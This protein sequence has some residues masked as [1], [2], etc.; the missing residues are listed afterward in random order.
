[1]FINYL[2]IAFRNVLKYKGYSFI[3]ILGLAIGLACTIVILAFVQNELKVD[4]HHQKK[5]DIVQ[6]YLKATKDEN[7]NF[8]ST[9]SPYIGPMLKNE[10][11]EIVDAIRMRTLKERGFQYEDIQLLQTDGMASDANIFDIFTF[12][13]LKGNPETAL[14]APRS[15]VLTE[16]TVKKYFRNDDPLGKMIKVDGQYDFKVT[17]VIEDVPV[18]SFRT[19]E[20]LVPLSFLEEIGHDIVGRPYFPCNYLTFVLLEPNASL[21][22]LNAKISERM[23]SEGKEITFDI[24]LI[25]YN[26]VYFFETGGKTRLTIMSFVA[27]MILALACINFVNLATARH[28]VRAKEIGIRKAT[29][30]TR[31]LI[32]MQFIGESVLLACISGIIALLA[33]QIFLPTFNSLTSRS[34]A[35]PYADPL[36]LISLIGLILGTGLIAGF[37]PAVHLSRIQP[38][39]IMKKQSSSSKGVFR[40]TLIVFQFV[41]SIAFILCTLVVSRQT[42][43]LQNF[44]LGVNKENVLYAEMEGEIRDHYVAVKSEL[45][46]HPNIAHVSAGSN[47]PTTIRSGSYFQWGV[48]DEVSRR[49]CTTYASYEYLETFDIELVDGRFYSREFPNDGQETIVVNEAALRKV[50]LPIQVGQPF[51]AGER[52]LT[53]IGIVKDFHHNQLLNQ[54]PEP[55]AFRLSPENNDFLFIKIDDKIK[56][57]ALVSSTVHDI[58]L[59]CQKFS[60]TRP[61][62]FQ[63]YNDFS[64][65][66]QQLQKVMEKL[67]FISTILAIFISSLGLFGLASFMNEQKTKEV[68][69]RKVLG[70]TVPNILGILTRDIAKWVL[71]ANIIAWPIAWYAM[72][73]WLQN[74]AYKIGLSWWLFLASGFA[75]LI[76]AL[77]TVSFQAIKTAAA[78]PIKTLRYE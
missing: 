19:F 49:L 29:G 42:H 5:A 26:D 36:F 70:A 17:A 44:N 23:I 27:I 43:Y 71:L 22:Q 72:R 50:G 48:R 1:M 7:T 2:K 62:R 16:S 39:S 11:P 66:Q 65:Q 58:Q 75:A 77:A 33:A 55:L 40:K 35:I 41:L 15:M 24:S 10:Y 37:Y 68:G 20:Y 64:F 53:L 9:T 60:R 18:N 14:S 74:F 56:D 13:F 61:L 52:N 28:M 78:N 31:R 4:S 73:I 30:A 8:Q 46:N 76:I 59:I 54:S 12:T 25:P 63:F 32:A 67:F 51:Y 47:L 3:N 45:E 57:A 6:S 38:V 69:I 21:E 34:T